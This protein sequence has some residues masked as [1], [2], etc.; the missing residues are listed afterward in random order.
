[1]LLHEAG[2]EE[3]SQIIFAVEKVK[4][5]ISSVISLAYCLIDCDLITQLSAGIKG[6]AKLKKC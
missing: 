4:S 6:W 5:R 3:E 2:N 1:M